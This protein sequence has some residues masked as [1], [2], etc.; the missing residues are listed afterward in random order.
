ML[1]QERF[2]LMKHLV[3][4]D[5]VMS[6]AENFTFSVAVC[7]VQKS[8]NCGSYNIISHGVCVFHMELNFS[9]S[10]EPTVVK[11]IYFTERLFRFL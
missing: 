6:G 3:G 1:K 11:F 5:K 2:Y 10:S 9:W 4:L 7:K 8:Y